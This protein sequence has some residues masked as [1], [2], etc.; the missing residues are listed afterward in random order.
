MVVITLT[1]ALCSYYVWHWWRADSMGNRDGKAAFPWM[2]IGVVLLVGA[3][4]D[5]P[6]RRVRTME[7]DTSVA[8]SRLL[9]QPVTYEC[10]NL[11]SLFFDRHGHM[12]RGY[13]MWTE[14]GPD[15]V[16]Q[17]RRDSC[18]GLAEF[19]KHRQKGLPDNPRPMVEALHV[20]SHEARHLAGEHRED[21]AEC[22]AVQRNFEVAEALGASREVA[23]SIALFY[24]QE[25]YPHQ[26]QTYFSPECK[27][28]G[29][30]DEKINTAPWR[31]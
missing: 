21:K 31:L 3:V 23:R 25:Q 26:S 29:A 19:F 11:W 27:A 24:W 13:V 4:A 30:L 9:G 6:E 18:Q 22:Q 7:R 17:L 15:T 12:A 8:M 10:G 5:T 20:V 14:Q 16:A 1:A 28:G 2:P